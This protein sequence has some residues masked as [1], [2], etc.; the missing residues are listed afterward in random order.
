MRNLCSKNSNKFLNLLCDLLKV[1]LSV[2]FTNVA[3]SSFWEMGIQFQSNLSSF[4]KYTL[5]HIDGK[6]LQDLG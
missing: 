3:L 2:P 6:R 5:G 1:P 4:E